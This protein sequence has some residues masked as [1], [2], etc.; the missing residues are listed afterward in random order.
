MREFETLA[1][2]EKVHR[3]VP[4]NVSAADRMVPKL[5]CPSF[6]RIAAATIY[7]RELRARA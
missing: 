5:A 2:A 1:E 6:A 3:V 7:W 4:N